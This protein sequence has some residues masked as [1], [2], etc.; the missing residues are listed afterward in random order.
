MW[1]SS[2][3]GD[4]GVRCDQTTKDNAMSLTYCLWNETCSACKKIGEHCSLPVGHGM[5]HV[6]IACQTKVGC[7]LHS[8]G[9]GMR[10]C[11]AS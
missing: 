5:R 10:Y 2:H 9:H 4:H 11:K 3:T 1:C 7:H 6:D 8:I